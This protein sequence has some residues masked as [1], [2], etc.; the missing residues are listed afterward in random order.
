MIKGRTDTSIDGEYEEKIDNSRGGF[1]PH[2]IAQASNT[3]A[4]FAKPDWS[5]HRFLDIVC[6]SG[7]WW[8]GL[9]HCKWIVEIEHAWSERFGTLGDL[10]Q[11]Q[12]N[13]KLAIFYQENPEAHSKAIEEEVRKV[14]QTVFS[15]F[16]EEFV[17]S[18]ETQYEILV[19]PDQIPPAH[20]E[21][22][23]GLCWSFKHADFSKYVQPKP[24][25]LFV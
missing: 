11:T 16:Q 13:R 24:F 22:A 21:T 4:W 19:L 18:P 3:E 15:R 12:A 8:D 20:W 14:I 9:R 6:Y 17:E 5:F 23:T 25:K 2:A 7:D 10:L 1:I